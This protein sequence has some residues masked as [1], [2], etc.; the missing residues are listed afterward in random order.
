MIDWARRRYT[1]EEFVLAWSSSDSVAECLR[2]LGLTI[3]G[4]A[5]Q[6]L[7]AAAQDLGLTED[8]MS[9]QAW[10]RGLSVENATKRVLTDIL[11]KGISLKS[12]DLRRR[13]IAEGLLEDACAALFAPF[14]T[15]R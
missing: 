6:N 14:Q 12:S 4:S 2:K 5:Y 15:R 3:Y 8:H 1:R 7:R 13:L 9:G 10:K 11:V